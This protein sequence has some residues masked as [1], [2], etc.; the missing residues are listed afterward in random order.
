MGNFASIF[1]GSYTN[2]YYG[3]IKKIGISMAEMVGFSIAL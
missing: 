3:N 2:K 1:F